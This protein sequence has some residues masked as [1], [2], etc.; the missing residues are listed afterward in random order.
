M[1]PE[2]SLTPVEAVTANR[3][4]KVTEEI[5]SLWIIYPAIKMPP[6]KVY[7]CAFYLP[8]VVILGA[9]VVSDASWEVPKMSKGRTCRISDLQR[10]SPL[11]T[12]MCRGSHKATG[13][14]Q[15]ISCLF[16]PQPWKC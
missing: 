13:V 5:G 3:G 10:P 15:C 16:R 8:V 2:V 11:D 1:V 9:V 7:V 4:T 12:S 14:H 6:R